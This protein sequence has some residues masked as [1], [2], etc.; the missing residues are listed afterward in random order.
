M[1]TLARDWLN[2]YLPHV[3]TKINRVSF[4]IFSAED[5]KRALE[6]DP[7]MPRSRAKLAI[8]FVGKD[9]PSRSSEFAHPDVI[10]G[11][12]ILAYRYSG[13]RYADFD[14]VIAHVRATFDKEIGPYK[15]RKSSVM[16]EAWVVAAPSQPAG[17]S[18]KLTTA[19]APSPTV[20]ATAV[21]KTNHTF[22][23]AAKRR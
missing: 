16:Y 13:L 7:Y 10:I 4:G 12:S 14:A 17:P 19:A 2:S 11:L 20:K 8:P 22:P 21:P 6:L 15:R 23:A 3:L 1:L 9:V 5:H 18:P